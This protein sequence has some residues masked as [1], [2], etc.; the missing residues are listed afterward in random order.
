MGA[1]WR[2]AQA[3]DAVTPTQR[4]IDIATACDDACVRLSVADHGPGVPAAAAE[5]LFEPFN[6]TRPQ[7]LGLGLS[8]CRTIVEGH[9]GCIGHAARDGGG[10]VFNVLLPIEK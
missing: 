4:Q 8:I 6:T 3:L 1:R 2:A 7:G 5:R 9:G 10:A